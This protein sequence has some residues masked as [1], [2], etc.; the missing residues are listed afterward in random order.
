MIVNAIIAEYNPLHLGHEY[1]IHAGREITD[2]DYTI[3]IMSGDY[4]QRGE[5]AIMDKFL[6]TKAALMSGADLVIELPLY[7]SIAS[8]EYFAKGAVAL[9]DKLGIVDNLV[10]GSE[11]D[12]IDLLTDIALMSVDYEKEMYELIVQ[13]MSEGNSYPKSQALAIDNIIDSLSME[14]NMSE[15]CNTCP[16]N[17]L[18]NGQNAEELYPTLMHYPKEKIEQILAAPNSTLAICYIKAI[19]TLDADL[20]PVAVKRITSGYNDLSNGALSSSAIRKE[21][22]EANFS[23]LKDQLAEDIYDF[24]SENIGVTYP[25]FADDF[26]DILLYKLRSLIFGNGCRLKANAILSLTEY[27][28]VSEALA[29]RIIANINDYKSFS[30]FTALI[31]TKSVTYT[32]I[33]RALLHIVLDIKKSNSTK[34]IN[35]DFSLYAR[36]LGFYKS[37]SALLTMLKQNSTVPVISKLAD[38]EE[39]ISSPLVL[40]HLYESI[41]ASEIYSGIASGRLGCEFIPEFSHQ[42]VIL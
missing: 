26:S 36:I 29:G 15:I 21:I 30:Q 41:S 4:V 11:T 40:K 32:H 19:I 25:V 22:S 31:K 38:C 39:E 35:N 20:T 42:I 2:A 8:A 16:D 27:L 37:S 17:P 28:D 3:V 34:Y 14:S 9:I 10:F 13:Y 33:S 1:L 7:Y 18:S 5:P 6:R 12:D 23:P 24:M